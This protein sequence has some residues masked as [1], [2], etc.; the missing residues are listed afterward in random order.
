MDCAAVNLMTL[1]IALFLLIVPT[2]FHVL[3][4]RHIMFPKLTQPSDHIGDQSLGRSSGG[5]PG[6]RVVK[7]CDV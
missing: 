5:F 2:V 1:L 4:N 3:V 6:L 7:S